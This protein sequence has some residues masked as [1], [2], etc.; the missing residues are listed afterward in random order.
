MHHRNEFSRFFKVITLVC[1]V[2]FSFA[3]CMS[4]Q[5]STYSSGTI[6]AINT[7]KARYL[8]GEPVKL[9]LELNDLPE[10]NLSLKVQIMH[11]DQTMHEETID[12]NN[13]TNT[14]ELVWMPPMIDYQGYLVQVYVLDKE[15]IID[16]QNIAIDVS[17]SWDRFPRYGYLADFSKKDDQEIK[18]TINRL[19]RLHLNGLLFYDW[20]YRHDQ[21]VPDEPD[22]WWLNIANEKVYASTLRS[23]ISELHD[24]NMLASN[25]NLAYGVYEDFARENPK[26]GLYK[27]TKQ[28]VQ[29]KHDLP[30]SWASDLYLVNPSDPK[31]QEHYIEMERNA[32]TRFAFD[33]MHL[34]T[35]GSRGTLY[36][37]QGKSIDMPSALADFSKTIK[38]GLEQG[39]VFNFVNEY[40][41]N[42]I[43]NQGIVEFAYTEV[44]P[45]RYPTYSS[46]K[47][48]IDRD[49]K[50]GLSSVLAYYMNY[51]KSSGSFNT[52]AV[53]LAEAVVL[54][55]GGAHLSMGD[56]GMLSS[57]YFPNDKLEMTQELSEK[58]IE[59]GDFMV[60]Y[61]NLLRGDLTEN[62][63]GLTLE[64]IKYD[65]VPTSKSVWIFSKENESY[66]TI[67]LINLLSS[68]DTLWR[69]DM[70]IIQA[71]EVIED[72]KLHLE[73]SETEISGIYVASPD[74]QGGN[75]QELDYT[76]ENNGIS[77]SVPKLEYWTMVYIVK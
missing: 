21:P 41:K 59:Y 74:I 43:S 20:Q 46:L 39:I 65:T 7:D 48:I 67:H 50:N 76:I 71:P 22:D 5:I 27:D 36:D 66:K 14:L 62:N 28:S 52:P 31:W 45:D 30:D 75:T 49:H 23:M 29:D 9:N 58:M 16:Q 34:D 13:E 3:S 6:V 72:L 15:S 11:L 54:A 8:P 40:A 38:N 55:S 42:E 26:I 64:Q 73:L 10:D 1:L 35:L 17:S 18:E 68:S 24:R 63:N 51:K 70:N 60:A 32:N 37:S 69:D 12:L 56:L 57:E 61:E 77:V 44:W 19:N 2:T 25:Y 47:N 4:K 53:L 33:V